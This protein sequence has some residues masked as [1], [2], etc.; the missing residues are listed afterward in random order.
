MSPYKLREL[1]YNKTNNIKEDA[2][3]FTIAKITN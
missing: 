3:L 2:L 1:K